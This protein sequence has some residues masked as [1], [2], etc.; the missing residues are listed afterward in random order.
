MN[1]KFVLGKF[2]E[3]KTFDLNIFFSHIKYGRKM[4]NILRPIDRARCIICFQFKMRVACTTVASIATNI[5][6]PTVQPTTWVD[7]DVRDAWNTL[8]PAILRTQT[9]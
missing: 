6:A 3:K 7:S 1:I 8:S 5:E 4:K 2:C 9:T